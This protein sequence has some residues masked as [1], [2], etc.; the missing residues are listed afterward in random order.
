MS[1]KNV[2]EI[3]GKHYDARSGKLMKP[4]GAKQTPATQ[5]KPSVRKSVDGFGPVSR[6]RHKPAGKKTAPVAVKATETKKQPASRKAHQPAPHL[7]TRAQKGQTLHRRGRLMPTL[8]PAKETIPPSIAKKDSQGQRL[9]RALKVSTS[10][11]V[12][13]FGS[14]KPGNDIAPPVVKE[15]SKPAAASQPTP[16][17]DTQAV[18]KASKQTSKPRHK[19]KKH[20][21]LAAYATTALATLVL[22]AYVTYLNI[23]SVSIKVAASQAG[24]NASLPSYKPSGYS[25]RGPAQS[26][27]GLVTLTLSSSSDDKT[28]SLEQRPTNWDTQAVKENYIATQT[29]TEPLVYQNQGLTIYV[30][31]GKASWINGGKLFTLNTNGSQ[32]GVDQILK[33]A[34]S[35]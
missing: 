27:P 30:Y 19:L 22:A 8:T 35:V 32:L 14:S 16:A 29:D 12:S 11:I 6:N 5:Q 4:G 34:A 28:L 18:G 3:N 31:D 10:S 25:Y 26:A 9:E 2:I 13:R 7:K 15:A 1:T 20:A 17:T 21:S 33:L 23:P 24:F